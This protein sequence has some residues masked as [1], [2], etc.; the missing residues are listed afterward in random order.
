MARN[1]SSWSYL[2]S[3]RTKTEVHVS[4]DTAVNGSAVRYKAATHTIL[5]L[6]IS[7]K[8]ISLMASVKPFRNVPGPN[9][10]SQRE[11]M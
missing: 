1:K 4:S 6:H 8:E 11:Y 3:S 7:V 9:Q 2:N 10:Y 5:R